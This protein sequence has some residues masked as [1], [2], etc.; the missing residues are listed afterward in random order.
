MCFPIEVVAEELEEA[1]MTEEGVMQSGSNKSN[2]GGPLECLDAVAYPD[3][4]HDISA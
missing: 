3:L 2:R 4:H 1:S